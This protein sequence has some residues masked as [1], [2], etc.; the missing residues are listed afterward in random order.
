MSRIPFQKELKSEQSIRVLTAQLI[1]AKK[2][3]KDCGEGEGDCPDCEECPELPDNIQFSVNDYELEWPIA[4]LRPTGSLA[5]EAA[6]GHSMFQSTGAA[7]KAAL[8]KDTAY[9]II[10]GRDKALYGQGFRALFLQAGVVLSNKEYATMAATQDVAAIDVPAAHD[11]IILS[12]LWAGMLTL[13]QNGVNFGAANALEAVTTDVIATNAY[14][15]W[16]KDNAYVG[17]TRIQFVLPATTAV[18]ATDWTLNISGSGGFSATLISA[19]K[20]GDNWNV[21]YDTGDQGMG[22]GTWDFT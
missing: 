13:K 14:Q 9:R 8:R 5:T 11:E 20:V 17:F 12:K 21:V 18:F 4:V 15:I 2:Q 16:V 10:W 19:V 6:G 7:V 1:K 22:D 3:L